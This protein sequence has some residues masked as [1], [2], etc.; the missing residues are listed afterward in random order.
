MTDFS[1]G[2]DPGSLEALTHLM[3]F[4]VLLDPRITEVL[5]KGSELIVTTAQTNAWTGFTNPT[6]PLED[7][8]YAYVVSTTEVDVAVGVPYGRRQEEGGQGFLDSLGRPMNNPAKPY[9]KP[10]VETDAPVIQSM[11]AF[12]VYDAWGSV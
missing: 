2:F 11:L 1:A 9:L 5:T 4:E 10:A 8:I 3:G 6:G 12:A 7:S